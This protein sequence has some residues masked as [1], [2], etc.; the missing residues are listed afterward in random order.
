[1]FLV[2]KITTCA[3]HIVLITVYTIDAK[4]TATTPSERH[5]TLKL[6]SEKT[7]Q[8]LPAVRVQSTCLR[9]APFNLT[10]LLLAAAT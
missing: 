7:F 6:S 9:T 1:M 4:Q 2:K 3:L 8:R 5:S 10:R